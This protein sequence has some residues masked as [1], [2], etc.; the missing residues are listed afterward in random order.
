[1]PQ[2]SR[3]DVRDEVISI[4]GEI[5][6]DSPSMV[7]I[8]E[9]TGL[10]RE[11]GFESIDAVLLGSTLE[12]HYKTPLPFPEFLTQA[13][14]QQLP[15]ITLGRLLDFLMDNLNKKFVQGAASWGA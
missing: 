4:I 11:L 15:D 12:E 9:N 3:A 8:S 1:M 2:H 13:R 10:F 7:P 5:R 6:D 14:E